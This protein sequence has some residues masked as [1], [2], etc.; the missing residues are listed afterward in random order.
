[1]YRKDKRLSMFVI[2][3]TFQKRSCK[4]QLA[5]NKNFKHKMYHN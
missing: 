1:M 4:N 2:M 3:D 5:A